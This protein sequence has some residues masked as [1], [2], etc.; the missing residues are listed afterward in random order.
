MALQPFRDIGQV[1]GARNVT[2]TIQRLQDVE[3][4]RTRNALLDLNL[5]NAPEAFEQRRAQTERARAQEES[6]VKAEKQ[7]ELKFQVSV[8]EGLLENNRIEEAIGFAQRSEF[9]EGEIEE[10]LRGDQSQIESATAQINSIADAFRQE[11]PTQATAGQRDRAA[12]LV[13][14]Q[15]PNKDVRKSA[16]VSLGLTGRATGAAPQVVMIAGVPHIFDKQQTKLVRAKVAGEEVT[17]EDVAKAA[18]TVA[19]GKKAGEAAIKRSEDAFG[20]IGKVRENIANFDEG[21]RLIDEGAETGAVTSFFPSFRA[22]SV[23]LDNLQG[24]LGLDVIGNTTFGALSDSE[25]KF[26]LSVALPLKLDGP[27]LKAWMQ[28]KKLSQQ[29]LVGYLTE[30]A[31]FLGTP[32]NTT[33]DFIELQKVRQIQNETTSNLQ[34]VSDK[35]LMSF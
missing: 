14:L 6:R 24:R 3:G 22:A 13:D 11:Q 17:P 35:D 20:Q 30:V 12:L 1:G 27:E 28:T 10:L 19:A 21:I 34:D 15:S 5:E 16:A 29:K 26:A 9:D 4:G 18:G 23:T 7:E 25:L 32:G 2:D 33:A 8:M 31:T